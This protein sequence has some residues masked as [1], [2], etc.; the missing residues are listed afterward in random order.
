MNLDDQLAREREVMRLLLEVQRLL[1]Q[2]AKP[3]ELPRLLDVPP[4]RARWALGVLQGG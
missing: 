3:A 1:A 4:E 2:G